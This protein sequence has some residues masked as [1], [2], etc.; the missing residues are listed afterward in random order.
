MELTSFQGPGSGIDTLLEEYCN[1]V[2]GKKVQCYNAQRFN[3]VLT[4]IM[5]MHV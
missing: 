2:V 3:F 4:A 1:S 5:S